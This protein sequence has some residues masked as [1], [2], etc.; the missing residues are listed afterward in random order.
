MLHTSTL[1]AYIN[2][3]QQAATTG[4]FH[5]E[6]DF[7]HSDTNPEPFNNVDVDSPNLDHTYGDDNQNDSLAPKI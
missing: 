6:E 2:E 5:Y 3:V 7:I 4:Q 1:Q